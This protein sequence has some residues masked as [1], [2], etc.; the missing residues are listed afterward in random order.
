MSISN[1][2][3]VSVISNNNECHNKIFKRHI[4]NLLNKYIYFFNIVA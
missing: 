2:I 4:G 3:S 1:N